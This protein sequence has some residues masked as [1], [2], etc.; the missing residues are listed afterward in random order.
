MQLGCWRN[1][2]V[3]GP[4]LLRLVEKAKGLVATT[5]E[6]ST[7]KKY[8]FYFQKWFAW[9]HEHFCPGD[10]PGSPTNVGLYLSQISECATSVSTL[11]AHYYA[12]KW[13]HNLCG[14]DDPTSHPFPTS[15]LNSA[16]RKI[17]KPVVPKEIMTDVLIRKMYN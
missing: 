14:F 15:I 6:M 8:M 7:T 4:N 5:K 16:K 2:D 12:I 1:L 11:N 17:G 9:S 10:F 3:S 13:A